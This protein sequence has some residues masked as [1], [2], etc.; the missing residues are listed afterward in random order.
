LSASADSNSVTLSGLGVSG[1]YTGFVLVRGASAGFGASG[2]VESRVIN[3]LPYTW[4]S[5]APETEYYFRAAAKDAF[6]DVA[7]DFAALNYSDVV[8][9]KTAGA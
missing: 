5:L 3:G 1:E 6:F 7:G 2:I 9:I 4:A 8:T